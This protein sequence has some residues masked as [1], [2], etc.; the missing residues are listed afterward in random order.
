MLSGM[1]ATAEGMPTEYDI[2]T[3]VYHISLCLPTL[4]DV[5]NQDQRRKYPP[6]IITLLR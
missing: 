3:D 1:S 5:K 4:Q 2:T 6:K